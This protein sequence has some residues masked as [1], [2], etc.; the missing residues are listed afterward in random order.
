MIIL[1]LN[2]LPLDSGWYS[3]IVRM[4]HFLHLPV[5]IRDSSK[6]ILEHLSS[7]LLEHLVLR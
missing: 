6:L 5:L 3:L 7:L 2:I 1:G 4:F